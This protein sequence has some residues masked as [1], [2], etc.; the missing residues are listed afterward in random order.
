VFELFKSVCSKKIMETGSLLN[1]DTSFSVFKTGPYSIF[2]A[3]FNLN[4]R[5]VDGKLSKIA[6]LLNLK[7]EDERS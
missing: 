5:M 3:K 4:G 2:R 7:I 6:I 1:T